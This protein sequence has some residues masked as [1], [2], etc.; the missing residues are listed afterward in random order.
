MYIAVADYL[1]LSFLSNRKDI[2]FANESPMASVKL[3]DFGLSQEMK[4]HEHITDSAG[5][6][7]TMAPEVL[8]GDYHKEAE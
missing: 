4:D 8:K 7:Y 3:I 5:T 1:T 2:L 6:I